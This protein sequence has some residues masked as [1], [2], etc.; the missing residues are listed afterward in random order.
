VNVSD[1]SLAEL[2]EVFNFKKIYFSDKLILEATN[3]KYAILLPD[4]K[5]QRLLNKGL[6]HN[7]KLLE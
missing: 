4:Y 1:S 6:E 2:L 5:L 3:T 7:Q